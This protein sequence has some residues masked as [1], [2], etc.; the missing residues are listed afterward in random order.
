MDEREQKSDPGKTWWLD[1][2][3]SLDAP[4]EKNFNKSKFAENKLVPSLMMRR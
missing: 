4:T 2:G 1:H 3:F